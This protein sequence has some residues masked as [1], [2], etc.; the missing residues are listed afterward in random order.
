MTAT[1]YLIRREQ[2]RKAAVFK[3]KIQGEFFP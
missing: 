1:L 2:G 3:Y